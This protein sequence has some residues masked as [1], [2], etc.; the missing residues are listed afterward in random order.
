MTA[1]LKYLCLKGLE[2]KNTKKYESFS[3]LVTGINREAF[4]KYSVTT[5]VHLKR[6]ASKIIGNETN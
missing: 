5:V 6:L 3:K 2:M 1:L 4:S